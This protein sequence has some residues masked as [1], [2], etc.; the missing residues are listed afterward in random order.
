M[1]KRKHHYVPEFY[2]E[3]WS[4]TTESPKIWVIHKK[5]GGG[6]YSKSKA[7]AG[8]GYEEYLYTL[9]PEPTQP[10]K[11]YRPDAVE[12]YIA[13]KFEDPASNIIAKMLDPKSEQLSQ[14]ERLVF[15][16]FV[17][18]FAYRT[19]RALERIFSQSEAVV[20]NVID[21]MKARLDQDTAIGR[22]SARAIERLREQTVS[23]RNVPLAHIPKMLESKQSDEHYGEMKI[24]LATL[25]EPLFITSNYPLLVNGTQPSHRM[26]ELG[27]LEM[28]EIA[29]S[30][31][32]LCFL[33]PCLG[34]YTPDLFSKYVA[35]FNIRLIDSSPDFIYSHCRHSEL[36]GLLTPELVETRLRATHK[37]R[38]FTR[39]KAH[40]RK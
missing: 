37:F 16:R 35:T 27:R 4:S 29:L 9:Q 2:L 34:L 33:G 40:Q 28:L 17:R 12:D 10:A 15:I 18:L 36:Q 7:P 13:Q 11:S 22:R 23:A 6:L 31:Y 8:T 19:P 20:N 24:A 32:H 38:E 25:E 3:R 14:D 1:Q 39:R 30:P 21:Q 26:H 5:P